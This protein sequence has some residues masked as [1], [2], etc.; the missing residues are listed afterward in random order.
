[1]RRNLAVRAAACG[2]LL[3]LG[4]LFLLRLRLLP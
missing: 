2:V 3:V 4:S 1:M